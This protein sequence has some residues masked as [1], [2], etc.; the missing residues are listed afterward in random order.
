MSFIKMHWTWITG[1]LAAVW[2]YASPNAISALAS[3]AA[4]HPVVGSLAGTAVALLAHVSPSPLGPKP[5]A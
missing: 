1:L 3:A 4:A 5:T 2:A